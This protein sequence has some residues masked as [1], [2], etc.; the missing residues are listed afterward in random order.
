MNG[1]LFGYN[2]SVY[3]VHKTLMLL[4]FENNHITASRIK[5]STHE[6]TMNKRF[7]M[8]SLR[9]VLTTIKRCLLT[10]DQKSSRSYVRRDHFAGRESQG[11]AV[12]G[13][14]LLV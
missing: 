8:T 12:P 3:I 7:N 5:I 14:K 2:K 1:I 6:M 4:F 11:L 13:K 10:F 9:F